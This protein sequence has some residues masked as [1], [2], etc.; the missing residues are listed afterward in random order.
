MADELA[1]W[2]YGERV[3]ASI[4]ERGALDSSTRA[5]RSIGM[6]WHAA[7]VAIAARREPPVF[8][9]RRSPVS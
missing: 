4:S 6:P 9:G 8:A 7:A 3:A 1:V 5:R 2:L